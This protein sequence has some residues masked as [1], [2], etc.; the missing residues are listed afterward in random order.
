MPHGAPRQTEG[1]T[2]LSLLNRDRFGKIG[3]S[4]GDLN[5]RLKLTDQAIV[6]IMIRPIRGLAV[7]MAV[8]RL[9]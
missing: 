5:E 1:R 6:S 2:R 8:F 9:V 4:G 3:R 7:I